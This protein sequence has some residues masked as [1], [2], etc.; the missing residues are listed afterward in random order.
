MR[1]RPFVSWLLPSS[2]VPAA[3]LET[4]MHNKG[5][6]CPFARHPIRRCLILECRV[7]SPGSP[8]KNSVVRNP[9]RKFRPCLIAEMAG[10][11]KHYA[12]FKPPA[13]TP[14]GSSFSRC[15]MLCRYT[16]TPRLTNHFALN[17]SHML[18]A[19]SALPNSIYR[20]ARL[21][22][23]MASCFQDSSSSSSSPPFCTLSPRLWLGR[24]A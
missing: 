19:K 3:L 21:K 1:P 13:S 24:E 4:R 11:Y 8:S 23:M 2:F 5:T 17:H 10:N 15:L 12:A 14:S 6:P 20:P 7:P 22:C 9:N 16:N 18:P